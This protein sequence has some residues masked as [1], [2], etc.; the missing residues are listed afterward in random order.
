METSKDSNVLKLKFKILRYVISGGTG[1][2][3]NIGTLYTLTHFFGIWYL[4]SSIVAFILSFFVSFNLQRRWTFNQNLPHTIV[5]HMTM[6]FV[7]ALFNLFLNTGI[8]YA[9]V[10]YLGMWYV[11]AQI[12]AGLFVAISSFFVYQHVIFN[13]QY[14]EPP[15]L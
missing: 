13:T 11:V 3:V 15:L 8:V 7:V 12:V 10:E 4:L 5:R 9:S 1:A 14:K 2:V 6:Y